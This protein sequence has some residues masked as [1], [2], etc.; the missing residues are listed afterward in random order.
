VSSKQKGIIALLKLKRLAFGFVLAFLVFVVLNVFTLV[1]LFMPTEKSSTVYG[2]DPYS[3]DPGENCC[4]YNYYNGQPNFEAC[5]EDYAHRMGVPTDLGCRQDPSVVNPSTGQPAGEC[6]TGEDPNDGCWDEAVCN[7]YEFADVCV[8]GCIAK[9]HLP[10]TTESAKLCSDLEHCSVFP[11]YAQSWDQI[12]ADQ[13]RSCDDCLDQ[14]YNRYAGLP[15]QSSKTYECVDQCS[16]EP[17]YNVTIEGDPPHPCLST[18]WTTAWRESLATVDPVMKL[19]DTGCRDEKCVTKYGSY[20]KC[21]I[22]CHAYVG[23][24][25]VGIPE[26]RN[27]LTCSTPDGVE[28]ALEERINSTTST[29]TLLAS[30]IANWKRGESLQKLVNRVKKECIWGDTIGAFCG[31]SV[32]AYA[33]DVFSVGQILFGALAMLKIIFGGVLYATAAGNPSQIQ[34]AKEHIKYALIGI[35]LLLSIN[36]ILQIVGVGSENLL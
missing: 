19:C 2:A 3:C 32:I 15:D 20:D 25:G 16:F 29:R 36:I 4:G 9:N 5:V 18:D 1:N 21:V 27:L 14:C 22:E 10:T 7:A 11:Q 8:K 30:A 17:D 33:R 24:G 23:G 12:E 26:V 31:T 13:R 34:S 28:Q 35:V 6:F